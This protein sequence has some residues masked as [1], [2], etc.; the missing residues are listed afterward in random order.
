[1]AIATQRK[2]TDKHPLEQGILHP[3]HHDVL[4]GRGGE[5]NKHP[6]NL[7]W[8]KLVKDCKSDYIMLTRPQKMELS[9]SIVKAVKSQDPPGRFLQKDSKTNKWVVVGDERARVK[10]SQALREGAP[11]IRKMAA[12]KKMTVETETT[13]KRVDKQAIDSSSTIPV[14]RNSGNTVTSTSTN[15]DSKG[16]ARGGMPPLPT[17]YTTHLAPNSNI[18]GMAMLSPFLQQHQQPLSS[19]IVILVPPSDYNVQPHLFHH[20]Q[21]WHPYQV[22]NQQPPQPHG[23]QHSPPHGKCHPQHSQSRHNDYSERLPKNIGSLDTLGD[24]LRKKETLEGSQEI[25]PIVGSD[26]RLGELRNTNE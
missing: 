1:M 23:M 10:T 15:V 6:G 26:A 17:R 8:R 9:R 19:Y 25:P 24:G 21:Q 13:E 2:N 16:G 11:D 18:P 12:S 22:M 5:T 3:H 20:P 4:C 7:H 14:T